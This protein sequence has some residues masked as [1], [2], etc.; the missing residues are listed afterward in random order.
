MLVDNNT[1]NYAS[2]LLN[3]GMYDLE[4]IDLMISWKQEAYT[5]ISVISA[6]RLTETAQ[7]KS[8]ILKIINYI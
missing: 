2:S 3:T 8:D 5:K 4:I 6:L 1:G 7:N